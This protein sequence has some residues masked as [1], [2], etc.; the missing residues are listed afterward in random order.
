MAK[1]VLISCVSQKLAHKAKAR[2]L[3]RSPLFRYSLEYAEKKLRPDKIFILSALHHVVELDQE[4]EPYDVTLSYVP[5]A[6]QVDNPSLKVLSKQEAIAWGR[7]VLQQLAQK[8]NLQN[9]EFIILAGKSYVEPIKHG[10]KYLKEPLNGY[11]Q[12]ERVS[13]LKQWLQ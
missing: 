6:K 9:D 12:G 3:Y 10:I 11:R 5:P 13:I 2:D 4:I 1:I 8:A 7:I